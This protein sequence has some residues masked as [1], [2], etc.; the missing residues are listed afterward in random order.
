MALAS[1]TAMTTRMYTDRKKWQIGELGA[2]VEHERVHADD[3][4]E[5]EHSSGHIDQLRR[6][7]EGQIEVHTQVQD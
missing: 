5:C 6:T 7:L 4:V 2:H 1:C 3:C